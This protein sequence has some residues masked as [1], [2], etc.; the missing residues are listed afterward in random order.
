MRHSNLRAA[1][2]SLVM[3]LALVIFLAIA[4]YDTVQDPP[5]QA[6]FLYEQ[7]V[8]RPAELH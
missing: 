4:A 7:Q 6:D 8:D 2:F 3:L 5:R 1:T